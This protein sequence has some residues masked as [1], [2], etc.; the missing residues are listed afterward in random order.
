MIIN[1][2]MILQYD[3]T[4]YNGWQKQGNTD[5]TI[6]GKLE[7]ILSR[8][9]NQNIEVNGSGR[10][11]AGV[12]A[13]GQVASF[14]VDWKDVPWSELEAILKELNEYLP[15]D[16]KILDLTVADPRFHA[17][18]NAKAKEYCYYISLEKK[19]DV[20]LRKYLAYFDMESGEELDMVRMSQAAYSLIGE[21]DFACFSDN[22]SNK[23]TIRTI[24]SIDM[25]VTED[26]ILMIRFYGD[27][28]LYHMV[29]LITGTLVEIG[30][31]RSPVTLTETILETNNR[32][33]V[34]KM[35]PATGLVLERV[36][37]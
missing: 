11:D 20:F 36:E 34:P 16:I 1:Y 8:Y 21:H 4:K 19:K 2:K 10:T 17:R 3:G 7:S 18:L 6:Q 24:Y 23:S 33:L 26:N 25:D 22:K 14:K 5:N 9:F 15:E 29:R 13:R 30:L 32:K 37:Y 31:D 27:G 28:F 12:H 35:A